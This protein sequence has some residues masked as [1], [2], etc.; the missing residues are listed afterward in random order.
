MKMF[1]GRYNFSL[2]FMVPTACS[3]F[4]QQCS[5]SMATIERFEPELHTE[6]VK[7]NSGKL[8]QTVYFNKGL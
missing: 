3:M 2:M 7:K 6:M 1:D 4:P 8:P 5:L